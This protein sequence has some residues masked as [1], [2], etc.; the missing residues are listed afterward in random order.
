MAIP[1]NYNNFQPKTPQQLQA[2]LTSMLQGQ[3]APV[4][5]AF[6][7]Q[8]MQS[9][10]QNKPSTSGIY[11]QVSSYQEV[12]N[13]PTPTDGTAVLLFNFGNGVF[14][15]KKFVNGQSTIQPFTFMPLN[16]SSID[17]KSNGNE[18]A[19]RDEEIPEY[20]KAL[21][22]RIDKIE[23]SISKAYKTSKKSDS[24]VKDEL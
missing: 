23:N 13:Y 24:E 10:I 7:Q 22:N 21:I 16:S 4:Y 12:E 18:I 14:Y 5:N 2:E 8:N 17:E 19:S 6:Q 1:Y 11:D 9:P 20:I 3:Y 15:S